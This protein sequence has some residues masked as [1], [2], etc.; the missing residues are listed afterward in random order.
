VSIADWG[1]GIG[2]FP[3]KDGR[4]LVDELVYP[5]IIKEAAPDRTDF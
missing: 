5:A 4:K 2:L 3:A 1:V